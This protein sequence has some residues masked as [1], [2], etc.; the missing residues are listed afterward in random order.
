MSAP[1]LPRAGRGA[2]SDRGLVPHTRQRNSQPDLSFRQRGGI[3]SV[4]DCRT[5]S[6]LGSIPFSAPTRR[7]ACPPAIEAAGLAG[8]CS[9][10]RE[11]VSV[12][13]QC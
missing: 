13:Q 12:R 6:L 3:I 7:A 1:A 10:E 9:G 11:S 4:L 5:I 2:V 8:T